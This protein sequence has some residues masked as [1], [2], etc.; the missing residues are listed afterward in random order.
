MQQAVQRL[1][2]DDSAQPDARADGEIEQRIERAIFRH[3][4]MLAKSGGV[5]IGIK[6]NR[7]AQRLMERAAQIGLRPAGLGRGRDVAVGRRIFVQIY[8]PERSDADGI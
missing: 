6:G 7:D 5:H 8:R 1:P 3:P 4:V 2:V